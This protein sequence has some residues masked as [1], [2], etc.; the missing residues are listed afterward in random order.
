M[1]GRGL[2]AV[3]LDSDLCALVTTMNCVVADG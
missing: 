1:W 3:S 2:H